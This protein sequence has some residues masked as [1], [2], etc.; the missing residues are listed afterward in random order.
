VF[1]YTVGNNNSSHVQIGANI[2]STNG[3]PMSSG[4]VGI[5]TFDHG[6]TALRRDE[7]LR[8]DSGT[9]AELTL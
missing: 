7:V 6:R 8:M 2:L 5:A 1:S 4:V 9:R 3:V